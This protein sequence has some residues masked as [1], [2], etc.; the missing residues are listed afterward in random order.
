MIRC[1]MK[2]LKSN[3][4]NKYCTFEV[5]IQGDMRDCLIELIKLQAGMINALRAAKFPDEI[6]EKQLVSCIAGAFDNAD[7]KRSV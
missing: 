1:E 4:G 5:D 6:I 3:Y 7:K 2:T